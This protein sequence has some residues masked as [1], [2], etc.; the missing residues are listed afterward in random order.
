MS[1]NFYLVALSVAIAVL[2]SYTALDMAE[3]VRGTEGRRQLLWWSG[4]ALAMGIGIWAAHFLGMLACEMPDSVG[5]DAIVVSIS[6]V[7][8]ILASG[9]TSF[10]VTRP[11][12]TLQFFVGSGLVMGS[13]IATMHYIGMAALHVPAEIVYDPTLVAISIVIAV[14]A[15]LVA[16]Y[17]AFQFRDDTQHNPQWKRL[18]SAIAMGL[19]IASLH[20]TG[21]AAVTFVPIESPGYFLPDRR[22][23]P[24][25]IAVATSLGTLAILSLALVTVFVDRR[26]S[27]Q[28]SH[29]QTLQENQQ[30]LETLLQGVQ[31]G[32]LLVERGDDGYSSEIRTYNPAL[33]DFL[34]L[35]DRELERCWAA[36]IDKSCVL[37]TETDVQSVDTLEALLCRIA[38][39]Q[40]IQNATVRLENTSSHSC[41]RI[42]RSETTWLLV[43]TVSLHDCEPSN[44]VVCTFSDITDCKQAEAL[45]KQSEVR[46]KTLAQR[47]ELLNSLSSQIRNSLDLPTILQ[48][49][50]REVR[51]LLDI[52]RV[53]V[54][55]FNLNF[56]G[57]VAV[58]DVIDLKYSLVDEEI[59]DTCFPVQYAELY[60]Q[61]RV[62]AFDD[63][64]TAGLDGCHVD[65]LRGLRV[66]SQAIVPIL[67]RDRLWG[68]LIA[69][70]C[71]RT[72][73]WDTTEVELLKRLAVQ[74]GV[75]IQQ[76]ELYAAAT[77]NA[78]IAQAQTRQLSQT[79]NEL[80]RTQTQ[81]VQTEKMSA[82]GQ[83]VAGI[84]H[85][86]NNPVNFIYGNLA[87][88]DEY[89]QDLI[90]LVEVFQAQYPQANEIVRDKID[91]VEWDFLKEDLPKML[92][93]MKVGAD[94]IRHIVLSLRSFSRLDESEIK[95]V[96]IRDGIQ[97]TLTILQHRL[98]AKADRSEIRV[99]QEYGDLPSIECYSGPL[100]QVFMNLLGN[101][102]DALDDKI[103]NVRTR[104]AKSS[105]EPLHSNSTSGVPS[106]DEPPTI[107][108]RAKRVDRDRICL[109]I[110]DN[111][112]GMSE[113]LRGR[114]FDPFFTTKPVGKGTG[115]GLSISY[116][117]V[118]EKHGGSIV[119]RS[120]IG[121]GT[122]FIIELPVR[123][124]QPS[125]LQKAS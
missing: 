99:Y 91:A 81:L 70:E 55:Q 45:L 24:L 117:I 10:F 122:E 112:L 116:Q 8:A 67:S 64:T 89:I 79:L 123:L 11:I 93:S 69:H 121:L 88:A 20:Y 114:I 60:Q 125:M 1:Y 76:A 37:Q 38:W 73:T 52:D 14:V 61:G 57:R 58:E 104:C 118:T 102:I 80:Q 103:E 92:S 106:P 72:R 49:V 13:G 3:R 68:L 39:G 46:F 120:E 94:R 100:N 29:T 78:Q 65:F 95:A 6:I 18:S 85:E 30:F 33:L 74:A 19:A 101:A 86:I 77:E 16:L 124:P 56:Q 110:A 75:A 115:L 96:D 26:L 31:V 59:S 113:D 27:A 23:D 4:G 32:I 44:L 9:I 12:L 82:L 2:A 84:A 98:K 48:T 62:R 107:W 108:I 47:E 71:Q 66:R 90:E 63:V 28:A 54:Y 105:I 34:S 109:H 42:D 25:A 41:E 21:M 97:S 5:Y 111:G 35:T 51:Q 119:C 36:A 53:V 43:N 50:V 83:L 7:P 17:L 40:T 15:S 87:H 22:F